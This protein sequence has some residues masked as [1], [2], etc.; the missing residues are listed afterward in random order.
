MRLLLGLGAIVLVLSG[1]AA[2]GT[3]YEPQPRDPR[4]APVRAPAPAP[5]P[6]RE[7]TLLFGGDLLW[8]DSVWLSAAED[9]ART[10]RGR[11]YDLDPMFATLRPLVRGA[12]LAFCHEEVPFAAPGAAPRSY[13]LFAAPPE[14]ARWIATMGWD[15]C[16]TASNHA[17]DDGYDGLVRTADLLAEAGVRH[18]GTFRSYAERQRPVVLTTD[19]GV[20]VGIVAGTYGTNGLPLPEGRAWSVSMWDAPNLLA[21]ARRARAAGADVVVVHLHGGDEYDATPSAD[22][23]ALV[24]RLTRS[25]DVDLVVGEHAHVVQPIT[26]VHGKLVVHGMGNQVAQNEVTRP[27]TYEGITVEVAVRERRDGGF[28]VVSASYL[29]TQWNHWS[30]GHPIR[31]ERATGEHLASVRAAVHALG[32]T[33][34]VREIR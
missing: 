7:A 28:G 20:R 3:S 4:P 5:D 19:A 9:H 15:A 25:P 16:T 24:E 21:Q 8:H 23:V 26:R 1:C 6:L 29:P 14:I 13:P 22:Q 11:R 18:V 12:D 30:P 17:L 10:G 33:P 34:G 32:R 2:T 27:A 31:I